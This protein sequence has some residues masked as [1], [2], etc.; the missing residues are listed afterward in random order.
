MVSGLCCLTDVEWGSPGSPA[1]QMEPRRV[2]RSPLVENC[3][4]EGEVGPQGGQ[5]QEG[6]V[7]GSPSDL[8]MGT[9]SPLGEFHNRTHF[10]STPNDTLSI[11]RAKPSL[12]CPLRLPALSLSLWSSGVARL[13]SRGR[14]QHWGFE[15]AQ[16]PSLGKDSLSRLPPCRRLTPHKKG[17]SG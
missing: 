12:L 6:Q 4:A 17:H 11:Q 9:A 8:G 15:Q 3:R 1:G 16:I 5:S 13:I 14:A 2:E 7:R 10:L